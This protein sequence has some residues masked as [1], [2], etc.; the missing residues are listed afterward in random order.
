VHRNDIEKW[1]KA[2]KAARASSRIEEAVSANDGFPMS[3]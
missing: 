2:I 1:A 3:E